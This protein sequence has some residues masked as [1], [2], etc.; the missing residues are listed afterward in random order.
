[1][2]GAL[3]NAFRTAWKLSVIDIETANALR[4]PSRCLD[5][6]NAKPANKSPNRKTLS[7][8]AQ[9]IQM[10]DCA[11]RIWLKA[12]ASRLAEASNLSLSNLMSMCNKRPVALYKYARDHP[13]VYVATVG[14]H[15][16]DAD[17]IKQGY[18]RPHW[19]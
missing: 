18:G 15:D 1:L 5:N 8:R 12:A 16:H 14:V 7:R 4:P 13:C 17:G 3:A 19:S 2:R 11:V 6:T 9:K 10:G